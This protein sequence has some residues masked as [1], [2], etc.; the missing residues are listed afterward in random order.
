[1]IDAARL[2]AVYAY[3]ATVHAGGLAAYGSDLTYNYRRA[4]DY[5]DLLLKGAQPR[6]L[7]IEVPRPVLSINLKAAK[8]MGISF[9]A[10]VL[11]RADEVIE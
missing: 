2:P 5:V 9:P 7:P 8:A 1:L 10:T 11:V 6:E 3:T 4:A